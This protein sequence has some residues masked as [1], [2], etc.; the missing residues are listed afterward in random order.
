MQKML[1]SVLTLTAILSVWGQ[2]PA[3]AETVQKTKTR[4]GIAAVVNDRAI[5]LSDVENRTRL[6]IKSSGLPDTPEFRQRMIQQVVAMLIEEQIKIQAARKEKITV[7]DKAVDKGFANVAAQNKMTP[8]QFAEMMQR[9]GVRIS[10]LRDQ[11]RAETAWGEVVAKRIRPRIDVSAADINTE[12]QVI[13]SN[14]GKTQYRLAEI[15]LAVD[16]PEDDVKIQ[17]AA[18]KLHSQLATQPKI[19]PQV[20]RQFS[21]SAGAAQGGDMGWIQGAQLPDALGRTV[22]GMT[23]ETV[24]APVRSLSGYHIL[25]LR[26]VRTM[27]EAEVPTQDAVLEKIGTERLV[28]AARGYMQDLKRAAFIEKRV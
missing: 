18:T 20:A 6:L 8:E 15:F 22:V 26:A 27:T 14:I 25:F 21:Q 3:W 7:D 10:T 28:R 19:F 12:M 4:D 11:I 16:K 13:R 23:P 1:L 24:S 5:S 2:A 17:Q 9:Q